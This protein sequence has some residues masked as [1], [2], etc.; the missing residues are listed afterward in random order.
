MTLYHSMTRARA[1]LFITLLG[2]CA[3]PGQ[4]LAKVGKG[5]TVTCGAEATVITGLDEGISQKARRAILVCVPETASG[6]IKVG[7]HG[8]APGDGMT[9]APDKCYGT[10]LVPNEMLYCIATAPVEGVEVQESTSL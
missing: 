1:L 6:P 5:K 3:Y 10:I 7:G 9:V 2:L 8:L 4:A